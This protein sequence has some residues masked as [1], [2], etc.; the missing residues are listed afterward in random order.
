M[1][2]FRASAFPTP[3]QG[4][5]GLTPIGLP[6]PNLQWE[7]TKKLQTGLDIGLFRDRILINATYYINRSSNQLLGYSLPIFTGNSSLTVNLPATIQNSG[8]ELSVQSINVN[9]KDFNWTSSFNITIPRN[10]LESF[11]SLSQSTFAA[12]L[13]VGEP[14]TL[15]KR[16]QFA[17][18]DPGTGLYHFGDSAGKLT[19]NPR[20]GVD[21]TVWVDPSPKCY[22]GFHNSVSFKGF[23]IDFFM[24]FSKQS[25]TKFLAFGN[26]P[27]RFSSGLSGSETANQPA[28]IL[29]NVWHKP[30]DIASIQKYSTSYPFAVSTAYNRART[31]DAN[32]DDAS[33]IRLKNASLSWKF[34]TSLLDKLHLQNARLFAQGQNLIT[35]TKYKGL[36]PETASSASALPPLRVWTIGINLTF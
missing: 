32:Y 3:Y 12:A 17:G 2:L 29:D 34:P 24:Q 7:E 26:Q 36:D 16:F 35:I 19:S 30:G 27:G 4:I 25:K 20:F 6:N 9:R 22:G 31:S 33:F 23:T 13:I 28:W 15:I 11:E 14:M 18:V 10:K 8:F 21:Q 1:N 5:T